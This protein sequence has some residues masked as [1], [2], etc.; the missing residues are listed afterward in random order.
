[1]CRSRQGSGP[2]AFDDALNALSTVKGGPVSTPEARLARAGK[3]QAS[4]RAAPGA[5]DSIDLKRPTC[6]KDSTDLEREACA[7]DSADPEEKT[8][9]KDSRPLGRC[10]SSFLA[11][12]R[13]SLSEADVPR[14]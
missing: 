5:K 8:C 13:S 7:K 1:M 10:D 12:G 4:N 9:A 6:A 2:R 3:G 14:M 11:T